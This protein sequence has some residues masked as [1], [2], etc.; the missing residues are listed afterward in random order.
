MKFPIGLQPYTIREQ[1]ADDYLGSLQKVAEI[2]YKG[3]ELG[4]PTT[5]TTN[6]LKEHLDDL[7]LQVIGSHADLSTLTTDL[8][9]LIDYLHIVGGSYITHSSKFGSKQEVLES[10]SLFNQI[11]EKCR[12]RGIQFLYHNHNWEFKKFDNEYALD[13]LLNETDPNLVQLELDTY[14]VQRAGEDPVEYLRKLTNRCPLLHIKDMEPG[15]EQFFAE[16]GEGILHFQDIFKVAEEIGTKW[17]V[18]EQDLCR[19]PPFESIEISY[20]NLQ[21][22][23]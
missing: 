9:S 23:I 18:V 2:G 10:A 6:R 15:E 22:M 13:I 5:M 19:R 12:E 21:K 8:N 4:P 16:I 20:N 17:L 11:G 14:W 3:I 1:L 7:G